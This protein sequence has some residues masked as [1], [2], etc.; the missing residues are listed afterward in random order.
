ML[1]KWLWLPLSSPITRHNGQVFLGSP[2]LTMAQNPHISILWIHNAHCVNH[3]NDYIMESARYKT[4]VAI[5]NNGL[6]YQSR[7][8]SSH[9]GLSSM[10]LAHSVVRKASCHFFFCIFWSLVR[11]EKFLFA[12]ITLML[13]EQQLTQ[14]IMVLMPAFTTSF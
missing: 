3:E 13:Q 7:P 12:G 10:Y 9:A 11:A 5:Q 6:T 4:N 1:S 8:N 14:S 2:N